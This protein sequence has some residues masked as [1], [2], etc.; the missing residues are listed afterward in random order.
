MP[1]GI[2]RDE[3]LHV[4]EVARLK[5]SDKE[6]ELFAKQASDIIEW[7]KELQEVNTKDVKPSP[8]PLETVNVSREDEVKPSYAKDEVFINTEHKEKGFFK[9]PKII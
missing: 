5:L 2:S 8:H 7:F 3:L 1:K 6:V 4:A 9:G